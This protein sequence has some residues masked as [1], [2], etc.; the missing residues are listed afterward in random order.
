M[1]SLT[2]L[3]LGAAVGV[4]VMGRR[5]A[6][7]KA[8]LWGGIAGTLPDLDALID[9]GDAVLN[10]VLHRA[11]SHALLYL[12][13]AGWPLG[14]LV[15]R[16][17]GEAQ[18]W[19]RW[20]L[21][22]TLALTTHAL[23]DA[24]TVY[25]TQLLRPF[26]DTAYGVGSLFIIDP[27]YTLPLLLGLGWALLRPGRGL[28]ANAAGLAL[29][30]AYA[31]WSVLAQAG[32]AEHA[33][34]SLAAAGLPSQ[35]VLVTPAPFSTALWRIVAVDDAQY[36]EGYYALLDRG[37]PVAFRSHPRGAELIRAHGQHPQVQRIAR[38]SDGFYRLHRRDGR[39]WVTDLRMGQEPHYVFDFD[40]GPPGAQPPP[41]AQRAGL[42]TDLSAGLPWLW[43]RL[44]GEPL[45]PLG[46]HLA[47]R[48][49]PRP[50][51]TGHPAPVD[52]TL[53]LHPT[54]RTP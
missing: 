28:R 13:L 8:A 43:A 49:R 29:S 25:G 20:G 21:A 3:A 14:W 34:Q 4:A 7:W 23:L 31:G 22:L 1:D 6:A 46:E 27:A 37:R 26:T 52:A 9:H 15:A 48:T 54:P 16:L 36:H 11:D 47:Q 12:A 35:Q 42:R 38:F 33:R 53:P 50:T 32:V 44:Q 18:Q 17:H 30:T 45:P 51:G 19:R 10:M 5:T 41:A 24:L 40:L 2:Q 39:L